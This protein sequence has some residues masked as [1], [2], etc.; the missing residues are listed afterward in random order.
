MSRA[1]A[2][3]FF[4]FKRKNFEFCVYYKELNIF[5]II[6][7]CLFFLIDKTLNCFINIAYFIKFNFKNIYYRI[8]IRKSDE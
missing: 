7:K 8:R 1:S 4:D 6:N 3:I 5:I 2:L